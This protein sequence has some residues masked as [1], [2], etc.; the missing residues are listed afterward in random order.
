MHQVVSIGFS[1]REETTQSSV[2]PPKDDP[3]VVVTPHALLNPSQGS[4]FGV[5]LT[6]EN[7]LL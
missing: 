7:A 1:Q 4:G 5:A 2:T 6:P 3:P